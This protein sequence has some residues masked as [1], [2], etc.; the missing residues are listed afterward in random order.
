MELYEG[1]IKVPAIVRYPGLTTAG[2]VS[3]QPVIGMDLFVTL[4][5]LVGAEIPDDRP[6]DGINIE[7]ILRGQKSG[8]RIMFWA[9]PSDT[10]AEFVIREGDWKLLADENYQPIELFN[11]AD[12][13]LEFFNLVGEKSGVVKRLL[14]TIGGEDRVN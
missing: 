4:V 10:D 12:D 6:I 2:S 13:P 11:L 7:K 14:Q 5:E 8:K 3:D 9:L 1:G